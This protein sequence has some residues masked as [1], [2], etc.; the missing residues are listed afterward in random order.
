MKPKAWQILPQFQNFSYSITGLAL[1]ASVALFLVFVF[2]SETDN[3]HI[4]TFKATQE[5]IPDV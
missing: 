3:L 2:C 5:K 4:Q 1:Y